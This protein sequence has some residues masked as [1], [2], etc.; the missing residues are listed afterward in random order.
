MPCHR[1]GFFPVHKAQ[2]Y[3]RAV[4]L[5]LYALVNYDCRRFVP[6]KGRS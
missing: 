3:Y 4:G 1:C 5:C 6:S 2:G